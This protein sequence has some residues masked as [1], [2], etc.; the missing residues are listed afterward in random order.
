M[1]F[2]NPFVIHCHSILVWIQ[3]V[4]GLWSSLFTSLFSM[5]RET[6][7]WHHSLDRLEGEERF[8]LSRQF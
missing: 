1:T 3:Q 2:L 6:K 8:Q 7:T 5:C 4:L